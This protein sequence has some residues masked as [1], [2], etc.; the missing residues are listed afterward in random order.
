MCKIKIKFV[1]FLILLCYNRKKGG[2]KMELE[3]MIL[4]ILITS[5]AS[6]YAWG[7]RGAL[8]GGE[9][10]AMLPGAFIGLFLAWFAGGA[11][12]ENWF[13][14]A[15]AGLMGMTFGGTETY[16]ETIGFVLHRGREDYRPVRGYTG[17]ALKGALWF[18]VC[19]GFIGISMSRGVYT[20]K[21]IIVLCILIP[22]LQQAG[23]RIFNCPYN[24]E[25]KKYPR[26]YFSKT[27][28]EEWG[29]NVLLLAALVIT[30]VVKLNY[31]TTML[32]IGGFAGGAIGWLV[33]MKAYTLAVFPFR[34]GKYLFGKLYRKNLIDGW[35]LME[36][37]LGAVGGAGIAAA[38]CLGYGYV[39][40]YAAVPVQDVSIPEN[41]FFYGEN[42]EKASVSICALCAAAIVIFNAFLF[43]CESKGKKL[44]GFVCDSVERPL[45]NVIPMVP[46]LLGS[47]QAGRI[48][49]VFMPVFV[50]ALKIGFDRLGNSRIA[51][52]W[53]VGGVLVSACVFAAAAGG[54]S[55]TPLTV[56]IIG[57]VLYIVAEVLWS[58]WEV[59]NKGKDIK[60]LFTSTSVATVYPCFAVQ[61]AALIALSAK[62]FA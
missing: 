61:A 46:V 57:T 7:M 2:V 5:F 38:F 12:R 37:I 56:I 33:A 49:A 9:K 11:I 14:T 44:N 17:L 34:N 36:F 23:Y 18:S 50:C 4:C 16:G 13:V 31:F 45:Y 41:A 8:I 24:K 35:K 19:G 60:F 59:K 53:Q 42:F 47:A 48:I 26:I 30:S 20:A 22:V 27:R 55:V 54:V 3:N 58:M 29:G 43:I 32:I 28:R 21:D 62:I 10:G 15:A 39:S 1:S 52:P 6:C 51:V 25:K 40:G